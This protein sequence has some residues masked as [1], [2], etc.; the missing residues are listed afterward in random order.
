MSAWSKFIRQQVPSGSV[1]MSTQV[2]KHAVCEKVVGNALDHAHIQLVD[3][4]ASIILPETTTSLAP[5]VA[6]AFDRAKQLNQSFFHNYFSFS[7]PEGSRSS[8]SNASGSFLS[9]CIFHRDFVSFPY[10]IPSLSSIFSIIPTH[11][12]FHSKQPSFGVSSRILLNTDL[13]P[14]Q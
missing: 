7:P 8:D 4:I 14:L 13:R 10:A 11:S 1:S 12:A 2:M 9:F 5:I 3:A 6:L